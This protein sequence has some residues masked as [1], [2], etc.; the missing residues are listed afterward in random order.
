MAPS[1]GFRVASRRRRVVHGCADTQAFT[2]ASCG[3]IPKPFSTGF[4]PEMT[5][6][7][8]A[9]KPPGHYD[10]ERRR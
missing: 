8:R 1:A 5:G 10:G 3:S 2:A 4:A 7:R 6:E 9:E